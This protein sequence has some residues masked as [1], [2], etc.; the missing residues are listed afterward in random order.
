MQTTVPTRFRYPACSSEYALNLLHKHYPELDF[1]TPP[2][3]IEQIQQALMQGD[4]L[5][6]ALAPQ[7]TG[8]KRDNVRQQL[9]D[10]LQRGSRRLRRRNDSLTPELRLLLQHAEQLPRWL[11][12]KLLE[13]G[14]RTSMRTSLA[15][16]FIL[17]DLSLMGGY[18]SSGANKPLTFTHALQAATFRRLE[19]TMCF[20]MDV[21]LPGNMSR[22]QPGYQSAVRVRVMHAVARAG[23]LNSGRWRSCDWGLPINQAD[24]LAT[25]LL[26]SA[27]YIIGLKELG[28]R[29]SQEEQL[30]LVHL[31]R[32]VGYLMGVK[33]ELLP[34]DVT[35]AMRTA[36]LI[37]ATQ[38]EADEDSRR[39]AEALRL[40]PYARPE[41]RGRA[42][43]A[44]AEEHYRTGLSRYLMGDEAA[45][46]L[47]LPDTPAKHLPRWSKPWINGIEIV[48]EH[49]PMAT[50]VAER[51]GE[52]QV[53]T[54]RRLIRRDSVS[55]EASSSV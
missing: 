10:A 44:R 6:D 13:I 7:L 29:L 35:S 1:S 55:F 43:L 3:E 50:R 18:R 21:S 39:L 40:A 15:G 27:S 47:G 36:W 30:G 5:A 46:E 33:E 4:P 32:Y 2:G 19:E 9:D 28:I 45:D 41:Y 24:M 26:F 51:I 54:A 38:P 52:Q 14:A 22:Y 53:R 23:I 17:R 37:G 25:N 31:W 49:V 34:E 20:W 8:A 12:S 11:D 42:W 48:R 16:S